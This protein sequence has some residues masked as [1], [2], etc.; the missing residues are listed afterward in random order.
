MTFSWAACGSTTT[1]PAA[2][3]G[4][5][6]ASALLSEC[7]EGAQR[8]QRGAIEL[9]RACRPPRRPVRH[10]V[11]ELVTAVE[12]T[13][14]PV[15]DARTLGDDEA[16]GVERP[17]AVHGRALQRLPAGALHRRE[18]AALVAEAHLALGGMHV[19]VDLDRVER[20]ADDAERVATAG[21]ETAVRLGDRGE[22]RAVVHATAVD[23]EHEAGARATVPVRFADGAPDVD[24][25]LGSNTDEAGGVGAEHRAQ[26]LVEAAAR[27]AHA[28]APVDGARD[29][30]AGA[31]PGR[32]R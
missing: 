21:N 25:T 2:G 11:A 12:A 16:G 8:L 30:Q 20:H 4:E 23:D 15:V 19:D 5:Q 1:T 3:G 24:V 17:D 9:R 13:R 26:R 32:G 7:S 27:R 28:G 31:G 10:L 29:A 6:P 18:D 14:A 22:Q